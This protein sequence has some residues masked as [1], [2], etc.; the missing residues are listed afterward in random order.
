MGILAASL[1]VPASAATDEGEYYIQQG[2]WTQEDQLRSSGISLS[3]TFD[4]SD[5]CIQTGI[6]DETAASP[7]LKL[8]NTESQGMKMP[9]LQ[10]KH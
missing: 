2:T 9:L 10:A 4:E 3:D 6:W 1:F 8:P 7:K 5:F